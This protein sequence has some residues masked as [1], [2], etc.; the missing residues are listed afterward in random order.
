MVRGLLNLGISRG[1]S[2]PPGRGSEMATGIKIINRA[3]KLKMNFKPWVFTIDISFLIG[4]FPQECHS[5]NIPLNRKAAVVADAGVQD[6][7]MPRVEG[8]EDFIDRVIKPRRLKALAFK[9]LH[10]PF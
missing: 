6:I 10:Y 8:G 9:R 7:E 2:E 4:S 1:S 3:K 5:L